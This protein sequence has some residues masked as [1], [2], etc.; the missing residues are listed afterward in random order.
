MCEG[1]YAH[2]GLTGNNRGSDRD[3]RLVVGAFVNSVTQQL[4]RVLELS[5]AVWTQI[6]VTLVLAFLMGPHRAVHV[7]PPR[8]RLALVPGHF[9]LT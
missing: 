8:T 4:V 3:S 6:F 7:E 9:P 1:A 2:Y 5:A